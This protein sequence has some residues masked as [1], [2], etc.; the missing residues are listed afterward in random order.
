MPIGTQRP[1]VSAFRLL[2]GLVLAAAPARLASANVV[3]N[4]QFDSSITSG[5][6]AAAKIAGINNAIAEIQSHIAN[7]VTVNI[8]FQDVGTGVLGQNSTQVNPV[9]YSSYRSDLLTHQTLSAA[10]TTAIATLP[11][12]SNEPVTGS[13]GVAATYPLLRALGESA[14]GDRSCCS[15]RASRRVETSGFGSIV[16][17]RRDK[18][19]VRRD[20]GDVGVT[21]GT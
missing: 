16:L 20:E 2:L 19:D 5:P 3:I 7:N 4:A 12:G 18:G 11:S 21:K 15:W 13:P 14:A 9:L 17:Y 1:V 8:L 6:N 10:D